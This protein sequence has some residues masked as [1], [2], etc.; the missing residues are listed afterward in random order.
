[1]TDLCGCESLGRTWF[2]VDDHLLSRV[3]LGGEAAVVAHVLTG[4]KL[5]HVHKAQR[6]TPLQQELLAQG[7]VATTTAIH[8]APG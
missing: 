5:Y 2:G 8:T 7:D 6:D 4:T 3:G 1:M